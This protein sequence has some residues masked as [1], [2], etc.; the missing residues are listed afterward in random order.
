MSMRLAR[1]AL[2]WFGKLSLPTSRWPS[3]RRPAT[4]PAPT[5][6][7][8]NINTA[9]AAQLQK[10]PGVGEKKAQRIVAYRKNHRFRTV[11][12][13]ARVRARTGNVRRL[14][15]MS[16]PR[17]N[18][19]APGMPPVHRL[20][21]PLRLRM[22]HHGKHRRPH[23]G[24][25][26]NQKE[27]GIPKPGAQRGRGQNF[28][29]QKEPPST[30]PIRSPSIRSEPTTSNRQPDVDQERRGR[31]E[32]IEQ[33]EGPRT[34]DNTVAALIGHRGP[35]IMMTVVSPEWFPAPK[36]YVT[37]Q[38]LPAEVSAFFAEL[39]FGKPVER[40]KTFADT[41]EAKQLA[42]PQKRMLKTAQLSASANLDKRQTRPNSAVPCPKP[43]ICQNVVDG[44]A[45][46]D[47]VYDTAEP[48]KGLPD[49]ALA[50]AKAD[51]EARTAAVI[52]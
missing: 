33:L 52:D 31:L 3:L 37:L 29:R 16:V 40:P 51:A 23:S 45:A 10:L 26:P 36:S 42:G 24:T 22:P 11:V 18:D 46:Y 4:K 21:K 13:L 19:Q 39:P 44:T 38:R 5:E 35:E 12:E 15:P 6:G 9:T 49:F 27:K 48:L 32:A 2:Y 47:V 43:R 1:L 41:D 34:Y 28:Q 14:R 17:P 30:S 25:D 8:V 20:K 50:V 7:V